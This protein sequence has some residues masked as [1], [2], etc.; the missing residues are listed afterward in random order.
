MWEVRKSIATGLCM[1]LTATMVSFSAQADD[2]AKNPALSNIVVNNTDL[3][4]PKNVRSQST[5]N[6]DILDEALHGT[7]F[8]M[9]PSTR[10]FKTRPNA[11][12][13]SR[14]VSG[15]VSQYRLEG[16]RVRFSFLNESYRQ[17]FSAYRQDLE[18]IGSEIDLVSL[19]KDEQLAF[20]FNLHNVTLMEW[21]SK[22]YPLKNPHKIKVDGVP[23]DEAKILSIKNV[24]LSLRDIRE[25]IV[26]SNWN[27][28]EVIY[29]FFRGNI[30]SPA[31]QN[32]AY[33]GENVQYVLKRQAN[34]FVNSLRGFN[35]SSG[36]RK[37]SRLYEEAQPF[38]F[39]DWENDLT[40]HLLIYARPEVAKDI[41]TSLPIEID[42]YD[43]VIADMMGGSSRAETRQVIDG[44]SG[45]PIGNGFPREMARL[46]KEVEEK[47]KILRRK[48]LIGQGT[49]II[50]DI[51]LEDLDLDFE[52]VDE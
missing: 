30:G 7:V 16:S 19:R 29:G 48:G 17:E 14:I 37:V 34:E 44:L 6:Y 8:M 12:L 43:F 1:A 5:L 28:P 49:V 2:V 25:K 38:Y 3:F 36:A 20:W 10:Q 39:P 15:H 22:E 9:G 4:R 41:R 52:D 45:Q 40:A 35:Q 31:L 50:E 11:T 32:Y 27:Q 46:L 24:P 51:E 42:R 18:R 23:L 13:G 21:I 47:A 33:T 26:F